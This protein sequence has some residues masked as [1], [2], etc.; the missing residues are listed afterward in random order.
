MGTRHVRC[1]NHVILTETTT[2]RNDDITG[3][4]Q[5]FSDVTAEIDDCVRMTYVLTT[6]RQ[7]QACFGHLSYL[8]LL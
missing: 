1:Y 7:P 2:M 4:G 6:D 8:Q 3:H 5:A